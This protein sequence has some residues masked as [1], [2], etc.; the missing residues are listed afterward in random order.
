MGWDYLTQEEAQRT[1]ESNT[2]THVISN[3]KQQ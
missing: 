2:L 3:E 1:I